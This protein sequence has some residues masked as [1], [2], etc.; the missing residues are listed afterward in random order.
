MPSWI[1]GSLPTCTSFISLHFW[2]FSWLNRTTLPKSR[3]FQRFSIFC[4]FG[5]KSPHP[6][7]PKANNFEMPLQHLS[8]PEKILSMSVQFPFTIPT[9]FLSSHICRC[10]FP[11]KTS[12]MLLSWK[13]Y[14][15]QVIFSKNCKEKFMLST[16]AILVC[17]KLSIITFP[18]CYCIFFNQKVTQLLC[19]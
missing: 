13:I 15:W 17:K 18:N 9:S 3:P 10:F 7:S 16:Y 5:D 1:T 12:Y 6:S 11:K 2:G 8:S 4:L 14:L 19:K